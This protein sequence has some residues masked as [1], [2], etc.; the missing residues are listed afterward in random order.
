MERPTDTDRVPLLSRRFR[1]KIRESG[2]ETQTTPPNP[3]RRKVRRL[4]LLLALGLA[5]AVP[6][7]LNATK[8]P[9]KAPLP[10]ALNDGRRVKE[11]ALKDVDGIV[12]S[13]AEWSEHRGVVLL[14]LGSEGSYQTPPDLVSVAGN[15]DSATVALESPVRDIARLS[16]IYGTKGFAFFGV[17]TDP[18][19]S[20]EAAAQHAEK[21]GLR[22]PILL[23]PHQTVASEAGVTTTPEAVLLS[24][25]GHVLYRG[26]VDWLGDRRNDRQGDLVTALEA[27]LAEEMPNATPVEVVGAAL[28]SPKTASGVDSTRVTFN[29][30]VAPILWKNCAGCHR[31]GEVGPFS[32]LSYRDAS[33]RAEFLKEVTDSRRMPPW[34]P[35]HSHGIFLDDLR[36]SEQ[37]MA[38]IARWADTGAEE[39]DA[40][41]LPAPPS[42]TKGWGLGQPDL[43]LKM[44][45]PFTVVPG[46]EDVYQSFVIPLNLDQERTVAGVEFR[47]G[48]RRVVHH[49]RIFID[50]GD[51]M[52]KRDLAEPGPG[53]KSWGGVDIQRPGLAEWIPGTTP[54]LWPKGTG[55][56]LDTTANLILMVHYHPSGKR[57]IDQSTI[58][59]YFRDSP[60]TRLM[61]SVPLW[62][63]RIDIPPGEPNHK[64]S[65]VATL[66]AN[67]HAYGLIPHGHNLMRELKLV[68]QIPDGRVVPMLWI[69]D[70]DFNWQGQYQYVLPIKLPKGTK[71]YLDAVYDNSAQNPSNPNSPPKRV[72]FGPGSAD[73]MLGCHVQVIADSPEDCRVIKKKWP[74][75]L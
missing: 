43:V 15:R 40:R 19:I 13:A 50:H 4:G 22:F 32:L 9:E 36:L 68:A 73:E 64:I 63:T 47:P 72:K 28:P 8:A 1:F 55:K 65:V 16:Q 69:K 31:P 14:F 42:F 33:K 58:G 71:L 52:K 56:T 2:S 54:R 10:T 67:M 66:P 35:D 41:D 62:S 49:A 51:E 57:E 11:F 12:H 17:H 23:D 61:A 18:A 38:T 7:A 37:E 74:L 75:A 59:L 48:N 60:P 3:M 21:H 27:V 24:P 34:K 46:G 45:E 44:P 53:F 6:Y 70:W 30:D 25:D 26:A 5:A 20:S 29:K 39:G